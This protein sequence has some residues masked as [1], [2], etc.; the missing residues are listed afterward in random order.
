MTSLKVGGDIDTHCNKCD[1]T[2]A[3]II[4]AMASGKPV[5]VQ[6]KTCKTVHAFRGGSTASKSKS[7]K[8]AAKGEPKKRAVA[9]ADYETMMQGKDV[10]RAKR[11]DPKT[12]FDDGEIVDHKLFGLGLVLKVLSDGKID[13]L[14]R[15]GA[16]VLVH[17]R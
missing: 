10:S 1:L 12:T 13:V 17:A 14:F 15:E 2:L 3:H 16:K 4:I 8:S 5:K 7:P 9:Q 11:Y 6:C